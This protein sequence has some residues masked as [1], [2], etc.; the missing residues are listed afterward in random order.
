M[1]QKFYVLEMFVFCLSINP[2]PANS[3]KMD[4]LNFEQVKLEE[5][6]ADNL[7][8]ITNNSEK[9][10][11]PQISL[12]GK[13]IA[14]QKLNNAGV[15]ILDLETKK[16]SKVDGSENMKWGCVWNARGISYFRK[17]KKIGNAL[18]SNYN[19]ELKVESTSL[20]GKLMER[21]NT[22]FVIDNN[23]TKVIAPWGKNPEVL[24]D[25]SVRYE[26][27]EP[28]TYIIFDGIKRRVQNMMGSPSI[29]FES[30]D[31]TCSPD[32]RF[33]ICVNLNEDGHRIISSTLEVRKIG[34]QKR[35]RILND[36]DL[37]PKY[38][39]WT[40]DGKKV[41]FADDRKG[42]LYSLDIMVGK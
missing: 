10:E 37:L 33:V 25:G 3:Q 2:L 24:D 6:R 18:I 21:D 42:Q 7:T 17:G 39:D 14:Y 30:P 35:K 16:E 36:P 8:R 34:E 27:D 40:F 41:I 19:A 15:F 23:K 31:I 5:I 38:L 28:G 12:D 9:Y 20:K 11:R 13:K 1:F 26:I 4:R 29:F 22:I 32:G